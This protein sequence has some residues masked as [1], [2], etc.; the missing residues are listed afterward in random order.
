MDPFGAIAIVWL[1]SAAMA[2]LIGYVRGRESDAITLGVLLGPLGLVFVAL[3]LGRNEAETVPAGAV[4]IAETR[5][6]VREAADTEASL[7]RA[8]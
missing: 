2:T 5:R 4:K 3:A 8:A 7:R 1:L 6:P